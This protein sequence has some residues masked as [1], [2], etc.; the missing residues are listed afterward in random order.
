M[1]F[2][3]EGPGRD[4]ER[5]LVV[6]RPA[7]GLRAIV[8]I[9]STRRGPGF[10]GIRR[11]RYPDEAAALDDALELA[12]AMSHKCALAGLPAGGAK[13]VVMATPD[14]ETF[15]RDGAYEAL[16]REIAGLE[17]RY[18]CGPDI[19]TGTREL[20]AVRR[21]CSHVNPEGNDAG[22]ST[23][24]GVHAGLRAVWTALGLTGEAGRRVAIQGL[25]SVGLALALSLRDEG[26]TVVGADLDDG[27]CRRAAEAGVTIVAADA[28]T[29]EPCDVLCPCAVGHVLDAATIE[30]LRCRAVCGSANNQLATPADGQRLHQRGI[31]FAPDVVV[32]AGAV[33]EGVLTVRSGQG[34]RVRAAVAETIADI[35]GTL[36]EV[37]AE[38]ARLDRPPREVARML[39]QQRLESGA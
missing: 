8:A 35:E 31:L 19:G 1:L 9:H 2:D 16:G 21:V 17:G 28:I 24:A 20:E 22:A 14:D 27:A 37:L 36:G 30:G 33:I 38:A 13:T 3:R 6:Q 29:A 23:A 25:G 34:A 18:V 7:V 4:Y 11:M 26:V 32:S 12:E 15:E 5:L 10:G 39:G